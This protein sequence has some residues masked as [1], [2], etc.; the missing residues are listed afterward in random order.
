MTQAVEAIGTITNF[1]TTSG[2][3]DICKVSVLQNWRLDFFLL[4]SSAQL[5]WSS[6]CPI[7]EVVNVVINFPFKVVAFFN[8][9]LV[10]IPYNNSNLSNYLHLRKTLVQVI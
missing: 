1:H 4:I 7:C 8:E 9:I 3:A 5:R 2:N 10:P 6:S